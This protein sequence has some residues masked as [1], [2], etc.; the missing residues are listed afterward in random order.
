MFDKE[1]GQA[2]NP[3][4]KRAQPLRARSSVNTSGSSRGPKGHKSAQ[5]NRNSLPPHSLLELF[6]RSA[7]IATLHQLFEFHVT[8]GCEGG[9]EC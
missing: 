2:M 4:N 8:F 9:A 3:S 1:E 6:K 5:L 7:K